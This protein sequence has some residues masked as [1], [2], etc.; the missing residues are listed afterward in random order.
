MIEKYKRIGGWLG[1]LTFQL[2]VYPFYLAFK[3]KDYLN[4][5]FSPKW[6]ET[7]ALDHPNII[8]SKYLFYYEF[9]FFCIIILISLFLLFLIINRKKKFKDYYIAFTIF[10]IIGYIINYLIANQIT[11]FPKENINFISSIFSWLVWL[12]IWA[13]YLQKGERPIN[14]FIK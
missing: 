9:V 3:I 13:L 5:F 14:T 10:I 11:M 12:I 1:L 7:L 4:L 6:K 8:W 2:V